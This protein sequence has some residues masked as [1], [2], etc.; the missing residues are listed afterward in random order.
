MIL[1][2]YQRLLFIII[3]LG[4]IFSAAQIRYAG[5]TTQG[6]SRGDSFGYLREA[7]LWAENKSPEFMGGSFYRPAI[8]FFQG[9][10]IKFLGYNDYSIKTLN[11]TADMLNILLI[12]LIS[13]L[14]TKNKWVGIIAVL[15]Y[16]FNV[17]V[18]MWARTEFPHTLSTTF[19]LFSLLFYLLFEHYPRNKICCKL[20]LFLSGFF[21][22][23]AANTHPDLAFLGPGYV[24]CFLCSAIIQRKKSNPYIT[25]IFNSFIF[26]I[27]FVMPYTIG[28]IAFGFSKVVN[29]FSAEVFVSQV[30]L[31]ERYGESSFFTLFSNI[32]RYSFESGIKSR[33][34]QLGSIVGISIS[35]IWILRWFR[36]KK[37][38]LISYVPII[39]IISYLILYSIIVGVF[40]IHYTR[41]F[42]PLFPLFLIMIVYWYYKFF[43][44]FSVRWGIVLFV[45]VF[46]AS[47]FFQISQ[48]PGKKYPQSQYRHIYD[49]LKNKIDSKNKV[50]IA[51]A[52]VYSFDLGFQ[53]DLYFGN[54]SIYLCRLPLDETYSVEMLHK[55]I[56]SMNISYIFIS[57]EIDTRLMKPDFSLSPTYEA[58]FRR[59]GEPYSLAKDLEILHKFIQNEGGTLVKETC[60]GSIYSICN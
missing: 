49:V 27:G 10:A 9:L 16:A 41:L 51:P 36:G 29:V 6:I 34:I 4:V 38:A 37:D 3:C 25:F 7:K 54:N 5:I 17:Y 28:V 55:V 48:L 14:L 8:Y 30:N 2:E 24:F 39:L 12:F 13:Y 60:W 52:C 45:F 26:S 18:L 15:F 31:T 1:K 35:A 32:L 19:V 22:G 59:E 43:K 58:W 21:V 53:C 50:M 56:D 44:M 33:I 40:P 47:F 20:L 42:L 23:M 11:V 57:K 46:T